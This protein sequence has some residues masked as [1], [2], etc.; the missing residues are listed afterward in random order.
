[1]KKM[2]LFLLAALA[3]IVFACEKDLIEDTVVDADPISAEGEEM[4]L[5]EAGVDNVLET[6]DYEV[7]YFTTE[8]EAVASESGLKST[9]NNR[10]GLRYLAGLAPDVTVEPN[11]GSFPKTITLDY[12]EGTELENGKILSGKIVIDLTAPR[13]TDS[14]MRTVTFVN[15][16]VDSI[17]IEGI[18]KNSFFSGHN[19]DQGIF[20]YNRR[21]KFNFPDGSYI[22]RHG[23]ITRKWVQGLN[24][25]FMHADDEIHITGKSA[26]EDRRGNH[27]TREIL[28][29]LVKTGA[30]RF[31]IQG[32][33]QFT[34]NREVMY[35]DYGDGECDYTAILSK[36][37]ERKV[38]NLA[39]WNKKK[40]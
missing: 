29:P 9:D 16:Y 32:K 33:V 15:F 13:L 10:Y 38:I 20:V 22:F 23:E 28:K 12:G 7:D 6:A 34:F 37:G 35:L 5:K 39:R 8:D 25:P 30:C 18:A 4:A 11:D 21:L 17:G 1:M 2:R 40:N 24:T 31:I 36:N 19:R 27:Y 3:I 26:S 14:A